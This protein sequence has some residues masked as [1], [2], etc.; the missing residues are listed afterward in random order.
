MIEKYKYIEN[1]K[2]KK[3]IIEIEALKIV[4]NQLDTLPNVEERIRRESLLKS[5]V[6]SARVEGNKLTY[7]NVHLQSSDKQQKS[8]A[9]MEIGNLLKVYRL[10][11]NG[12]IPK[13]LTIQF[14][15][16]LHKLSMEKI[17]DNAGKFRGAPW[18]IFNTAGIAIYIAPPHFDLD[19]LMKS[20]VKDITGFKG[21]PLVKAA[22]AQFV[23]EKIHPFADGNGRVGRLISAYIL[24]QNNFG[25]RGLVSIEE[26]VD[27]NRERYYYVLEP[28]KEMTR[29][30]EFFL[31]SIV[32]QATKMLNKL[33]EHPFENKED[34]LLPRR[35]EILQIVKEHSFC[36]FDFIR[37]RFLSINVKTLH[38]DLKKLQDSGFVI[39]VGSTRGSL[40]KGSE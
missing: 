32:S 19:I 34:T 2:V 18:A 1:E 23:F 30:I 39:K 37:R 21:H 7:K 28:N 5:A 3:L 8:L 11:N 31:E 6:F 27:E 35:R 20:F 15:E 4:F 9:R 36:S 22:I 24:G 29:F 40:Y 10:I 33:K 17:T 16:R 12:R 38:Y 14:I 26:Y 13:T 25:F